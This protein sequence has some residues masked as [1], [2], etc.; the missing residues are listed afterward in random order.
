MYTDRRAHYHNKLIYGS[1]CFGGVVYKRGVS[2]H[3]LKIAYT[4]ARYLPKRMF[5]L[6]HSVK[7]K[8]EI[9]LI[10]MRRGGVVLCR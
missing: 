8:Y 3:L 4:L 7:H 6:Y 1:G 9:C 5:L 10:V 2:H